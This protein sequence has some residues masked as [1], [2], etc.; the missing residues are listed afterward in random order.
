MIEVAPH[1]RFG[2]PSQTTVRS[3]KTRISVD[4][5]EASSFQSS[6]GATC[7][8]GAW[9]RNC[10]TAENQRSTSPSTS[11]LALSMQPRSSHIHGIDGWMLNSDKL[12]PTRGLPA[13]LSLTHT[14]RGVGGK[15][16]ARRCIF[17]KFCLHLVTI[18]LRLSP[19][20]TLLAV[21]TLFNRVHTLLSFKCQ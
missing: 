20:M 21:R 18:S 2:V 7:I 8:P 11:R 10:I 16:T 9:W 12:N 5:V 1:P 6:I 13:P 4:Q 14:D 3:A 15:R 17:H 19:K